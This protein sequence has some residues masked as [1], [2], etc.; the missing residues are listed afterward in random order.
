M[1]PPLPSRLGSDA[2]LVSAHRGALNRAPE[3]TLAA[4]DLAVSDGAEM[5]ELDLHPTLDGELVVI[6]DVTTTRTAGVE[7]HVFDLSTAALRR[8]D[9]GTWYGPA[10]HRERI[11]TLAEVLSR[12]KHRVY[13]NLD[14]RNYPYSRHYDLEHTAE[15]IL[16]AVESA[17][18]KSQVV[19]QC[20]DHQLGAEVRRRDADCMVGITQHGRPVH[21][22]A[23]ATAA[24]A[25]LVSA[26]SAFL[27]E[28]TVDAFHAAGIAVMT[29]VELR[30]P[31][32]DET[33]Q[34]TADNLDRLIRLGVDIVT[35]DDVQATLAAVTSSPHVDRLG[36]RLERPGGPNVSSR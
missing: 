10:F 27:D 21:P 30:L 26:D 14:V 33:E 32:A 11:P 29:S 2:P 20:A 19:I 8:L 28:A 15:R 24:G 35:T 3:N 13:L 16:Q 18:V 5:I 7:K 22:T 36:S 25:M 1:I 23:A 12:A 34:V 4:F 6:H 31:G 17:D 9:V